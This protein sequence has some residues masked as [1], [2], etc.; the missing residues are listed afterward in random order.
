MNNLV[1]RGKIW[2]STCS[3]FSKNNVE[4]HRIE[5]N[6]DAF[7]SIHKHEHKTNV[8]FVEQGS[9]KITIYR[10]DAGKEIKDETILGPG[11]MTYVEPGLYH[12]FEAL[13]NTIAFEIYFVELDKNDIVRS[14]MGGVK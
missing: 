14:T 11:D 4:I 13:E 6:K 1:K 3:L 12:K 9:L 8:F 7:C 10:P 5:A 2:G